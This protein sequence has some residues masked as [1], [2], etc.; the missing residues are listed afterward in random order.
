MLQQVNQTEAR[1]LE[2]SCQ[3]VSPMDEPCDSAATFHC[4]ICGRWFCAVHATMRPGTSASSSR[5]TKGARLME[6]F[7]FPRISMEERIT[8]EIEANAKVENG[9][10]KDIRFLS[11]RRP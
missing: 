5:V 9:E 7:D 10:Y 11:V 1:N 2:W 8:L 3:A 4:G 6:P